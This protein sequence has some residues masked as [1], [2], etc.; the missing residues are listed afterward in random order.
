MRVFVGSD[1]FRS[2]STCEIRTGYH[3]CHACSWTNVFAKDALSS[4]G[5]HEGRHTNHITSASR[6]V[7]GNDPPTR[8]EIGQ[9]TW[10]ERAWKYQCIRLTPKPKIRR[11]P[12]VFEA[13]AGA[14]TGQVVYSRYDR[15]C[16]SPRRAPNAKIHRVMQ[17]ASLPR[18]THGY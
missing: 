11:T 6:R 1:N 12:E 3:M 5:K 14:D 18:S 16:H 9:L 13:S 17:C 15:I 4:K 8:L 2:K 7:P 10:S